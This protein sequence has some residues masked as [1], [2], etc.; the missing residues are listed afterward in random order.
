[1]KTFGHAKFEAHFESYT[2]GIPKVDAILLVDNGGFPDEAA[3]LLD[4][5]KQQCIGMTRYQ[6]DRMPSNPAENAALPQ[7][8]S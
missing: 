4:Q 7:Q 5:L 8:A 3:R 1:M 6:W 2:T